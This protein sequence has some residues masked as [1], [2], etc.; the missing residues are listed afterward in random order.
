MPDTLMEAAR[1]LAEHVGGWCYDACILSEN[2]G[3][4]ADHI[5]AALNAYA[6]ERFADGVEATHDA[7]VS[8]LTRL[9]AERDAALARAEA[10]EAHVQGLTDDYTTLEMCNAVAEERVRALAAL[11]ES[12]A[13]DYPAEGKY[14]AAT[15]RLC[16]RELRAALA[17]AAPEQEGGKE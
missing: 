2:Q 11:W 17:K 12:Q 5:A 16:A 9:Q 6:A 10:A 7:D 4:A 3:L 15:V 1:K 8:A 14:A 13:A